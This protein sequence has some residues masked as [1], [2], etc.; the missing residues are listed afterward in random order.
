MRVSVRRPAPRLDL[1]A[2]EG[3]GSELGVTL[4]PPAAGARGS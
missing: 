4:A 2:G 1:T 3:Q